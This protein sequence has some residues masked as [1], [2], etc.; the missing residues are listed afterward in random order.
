MNYE[1]KFTPGPWQIDHYG[2]VFVYESDNDGQITDF[3]VAEIQSLS[4]E[5]RKF[6]AHLIAAAPDL[7]QAAIRIIELSEHDGGHLKKGNGAFYLNEIKQAINKALNI[8][9]GEL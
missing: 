7:L 4:D 8:K 2:D 5:E 1:K 9:N 6:N 3:M